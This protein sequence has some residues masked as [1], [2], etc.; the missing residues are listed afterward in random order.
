[1]MDEKPQTN[2]DQQVQYQ[3]QLQQQIY[4]QQQNNQQPTPQA[5]PS[6]AAAAADADRNLRLD[7]VKGIKSLSKEQLNLLGFVMSTSQY[8]DLDE[9]DPSSKKEEKENTWK[10][11][12]S[13]ELDVQ[14]LSNAKIQFLK[15]FIENPQIQNLFSSML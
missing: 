15:S 8:K 10:Q 2:L 11:N 4:T 7:L 14:T 13:I 6:A 5:G 9:A 3:Q 1:M 12:Y